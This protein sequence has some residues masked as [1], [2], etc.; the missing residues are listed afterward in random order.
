VTFQPEESGY[1]QVCP[2]LGL[3]DDADSHATYST[4]AHRC[5]NLPNPTKIALPHQE[6]YCLV[7]NHVACPVYQG[8]GIPGGRAGAAA[9]AAAAGG[10]AMA[11]STAPFA[12]GRR[13]TEPGVLEPK[14]PI[15]QG[16]GG[17]RP[18]RRRP[19]A[20]GPRPRGGGVS[21][22]VATIALFALAIGVIALAIVV[23]QLAGGGDEDN[24]SPADRLRTQE[25]QQTS[26]PAGAETVVTQATSAATTPAGGDATTTQPAATQTPDVEPTEEPGGDGD[27]YVVQAGDICATI[28]E[29]LGVDLQ[30]LLDANDM[31]TEDCNS[32]D[33]GQE[34]IIP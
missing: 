17:G 29:E 18:P 15:P 3:A 16:A 33:I 26:T 10:G 27:V 8:Q 2:H 32:L 34:L 6:T 4:E 24:L 25:A 19:P 1:T 13:G 11:A 30:D 21:M 28:A 7:A 20:T 12:S 31:T 5:Y 14:A 23:T 9:G 22:P